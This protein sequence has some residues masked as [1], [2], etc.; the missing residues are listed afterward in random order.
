VGAA[1]TDE[2]ILE[3]I[4]KVA[5]ATDKAVSDEIMRKAEAALEN[6]ESTK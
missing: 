4:D 5:A 2:E 3:S 1:I 6:A